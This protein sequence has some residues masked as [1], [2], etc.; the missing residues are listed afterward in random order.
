M[1]IP[2]ESNVASKLALLQQTFKQQLPDKISEV[3]RLW[4]SF[5]QNHLDTNLADLHRMAH[6]L[7][8]SGGTFGAVAVSTMAR[9]LEQMLKPLLDEPDLALSISDVVHQQI[10]EAISQLKQVTDSWVPS[11]IAYI[12]PGEIKD[13]REGD[14]IYLA[15]DDELLAADIVVKLEQADYRVRHFVDLG[16]FEAACDHELPTVIIMDIVFKEGDV[17]GADVIARIKNKQQAFPP[18]I[19]ISVRDDVEVRLAAARAGANRYFCKPLEMK[20]LIQTLDGLTARLTAQPYR[21]LLIDDDEILLEYYS[22]VLRDAGMDVDTLSNP[23]EGLKALTEFKPDITVMDVY[24]PAC[25]GPELA[26]VIRQDDA[27]AMMPIMFLSTESDLN[28]QLAAMNLGGDD[29]LVKPVEA[30]HLVAAVFARAK[31]ARWTNRLNKDLQ[32]TLRE[33]QY[34]IIT[35]DQHDIVSTTD[36]KGKILSVNDRFCTV[37]GYSREELLGQNHRMLKSGIHNPSLYEELWS[38]ISTGKIWRGTICNRKK[39]GDEY[40]V[41]S[42]IVPFLDDKGIPY[43]YVSARTDITESRRSRERLERGQLYAGIGTWDWDIRSNDVYWSSKV[44]QLYGYSSEI[45]EVKYEHF[46]N[47]VH[48]EDKSAVEDAINACL[49]QGIKYDIEHRVVWPD[50]SVHWM[51]ERGDV[52]RN[53]DGEPLHFLGVVQDI[54]QQKSAELDLIEAR[55]EAEVANRAKSQFLSSMSHELRTPMNAILGFSQL[56]TMDTKQPLNEVQKD[57]LDEIHKAGK[58]LLELIND[59]LDLAKV[60]AGRIDLSIE[61]IVTAEVISE[62]L[63]LI[64]P[65]AQKR[66]IEVTLTQD[67]AEFTIEQLLSLNN[68][69]RADR[70]RLKQVLLNLLSNAVKYNRENGKII[71]DCSSADNN[72]TRISVIDTGIGMDS[73]Q[74]SQLFKAFERLGAEQTEVEGSGIGLM[75]TKNIIELMGGTIGMTSQ[76]NVGSTFWVELPSDTLHPALRNDIDEKTQPQNFVDMEY[77]RTVL[78]IEDNPANLRLIAQVLGQSPSLHLWS[79][80]EPQLGLELATEHQ[81][82]LILLDINLPGIDGYEVLKR[83]RQQETTRHIPVIAISANAMPCDIKKGMNAGFNNYITKPIDIT[84]FLQAIEKILSTS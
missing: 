53:E 10:G 62:S 24:M 75:I 6:S 21:V 45:S 40:W 51:L 1:N 54:T 44:K 4:R 25:S 71:I 68:A 48:P 30:G 56:L 11:E 20:K 74:Q 9:E 39:N 50:G 34:Q 59:V 67:G 60:E 37:S 18:V 3:E 65:L 57:S 46:I 16:D 58:H 35:M 76:P 27:W 79:A 64:A 17:A 77:E 61:E 29:F 15:E 2:T 43:K 82:D 83:L 38:T 78:Y 84:I 23:M 41:E 69:V 22:T 19:F 52:L 26:Q 49:E 55:K 63:Q 7:A 5:C 42:T 14:L 70:V 8:G 81:P 33:N 66:G 32:H 28:R 80:H 73:M 36:I 47:I 31:R 13:P 12:H 72:L